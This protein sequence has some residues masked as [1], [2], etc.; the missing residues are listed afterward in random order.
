M[1]GIADLREC[2]RRHSEFAR[3]DSAEREPVAMAEPLSRDEW[4]QLK[5]LLT[6][7]V[8]T[9]FDNWDLFRIEGTAFGTI[10]IT[11]SLVAQGDPELY[12]LLDP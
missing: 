12:G 1:L 7:Y 9:E 5:D 8:D 2:S 11:L 6:R 10:Y 4:R 3:K